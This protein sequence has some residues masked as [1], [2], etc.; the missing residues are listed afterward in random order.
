MDETN[1]NEPLFELD[2]AALGQRLRDVQVP[3][4][5]RALLLSIPDS[6][7]SGVS[8]AAMVGDTRAWYSRMGLVAT[9]AATGLAAVFAWHYFGNSARD[10]ELAGQKSTPTGTEALSQNQVDRFGGDST[11][12]TKQLS[13]DA[14]HDAWLAQQHARRETLRAELAAIELEEIERHY[15]TIQDQRL[16]L[17]SHRLPRHGQLPESEVV[18]L[19]FALSGETMHQWAGA[20]PVVRETLEQVVRVLPDTKGSELAKQ[21][22]SN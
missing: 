7:D 18:A 2:D 3:E 5:L 13:K 1:S 11:G 8:R 12:S 17:M 16:E 14:E 21:I 20:T 6:E 10:A 9:V 15:Y 19:A 4:Q 22:L